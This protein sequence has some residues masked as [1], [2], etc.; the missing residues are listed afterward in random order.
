MKKVIGLGGVFIKSNDPEKLRNWYKKH[1][2]IAIEEWGC[3]FPWQAATEETGDA[4]NV[5]SIMKN[6]TKHFEPSTQPFMLNFVVADASFLSEELK[7]DGAIV[8]DKIEESEYGK[9]TWVMDCDGN[10]IELWEAP[11]K[12]IQK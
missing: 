9:F 6:D 7:K 4:Y 11:K 5:F 8:S 3:M 12:D 1:L 2:G 10:K